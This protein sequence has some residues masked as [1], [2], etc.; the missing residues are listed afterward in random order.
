MTISKTPVIS[1]D[2]NEYEQQV[3]IRLKNNYESFI[4]MCIL[5]SQKADIDFYP[6]FDSTDDIIE[7]SMNSQELIHMVNEWGVE[8]EYNLINVNQ[9][10]DVNDYF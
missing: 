9:E 7:V 2:V 5:M 8:Y 6:T 10:L 1:S 4:S 3:F